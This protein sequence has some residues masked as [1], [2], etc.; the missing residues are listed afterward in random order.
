MNLTF[1]PEELSLAEMLARIG[2]DKAPVLANSAEGLRLQRTIARG[3]I[4]LIWN[5]SLAALRRGYRGRAPVDVRAIYESAF[6]L[7]AIGFKM[8]KP[9]LF[10]LGN[11]AILETEPARVVRLLT[12]RLG[13]IVKACNPENV[14]EVGCGHGRNLFHIANMLPRVPCVGFDLT[15]SAIKATQ[16]AQSLDLPE[17]ELGRFYGWNSEGMDN[18]QRV[19]FRQGSAFDLPVADKAFDIVFTSAALEQMH[20]GI[21]NALA[22]LRR[23]ARRYVLMLEPFADCNDGPGRLYLWA[24]NLFRKRISELHAHGLEPIRVWKALPVKPTFAYA[25]VLCRPT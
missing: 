25:F 14:C 17:T 21:E 18:I 11:E 4:H 1:L 6:Q 24:H 20:V 19:N 22:E 12:Q 13:E 3:I 15:E 5:E 16:E 2:T 10:R 7:P 9:I 23:T 8:G